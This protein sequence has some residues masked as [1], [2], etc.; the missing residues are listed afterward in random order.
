MAAVAA[1]CRP[2]AIAAAAAT[3]AAA[4][5]GGS[6][7]TLSADDAKNPKGNISWCIGKDTTGAFAAMVKQFNDANPNAK[8]KLIEL[9]TSADHQ[10]AQQV[11][12]LRAKSSECDVL[13]IDTIWTAEYASQG[14]LYD[15]TDALSSRKSQFI[16]S[17][18][19]EREVPGQ[20]VGDPVQHERRI[21]LLPH[22]Q[23]EDGA[24]DVAARAT[25][26]ASRTAGSSTRARATRA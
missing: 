20:V 3:A 17:T 26:C 13:G 4:R 10:R 18:I 23:G 21:P 7:K 9:P 25:G 12:R 14:W 5:G 15:V 22:G 8:V 11:Q 16:G 19:D 24:E 6:G 1:L 2:D